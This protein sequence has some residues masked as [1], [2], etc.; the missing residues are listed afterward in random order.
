[1]FEGKGFFIW[2][3]EKCAPDAQTLVKRA[4][5]A[6]LKHVLIKIADGDKMFPI[7]D[8][9]GSKEK[10][11][12]ESIAALKDAGITVGGWSFIY[13]SKP[14]PRM[15]ARRFVQRLHHFGL[16]HA[17]I[18][19]EK[20]RNNPWT[21]ENAQKFMDEF[22]LGLGNAKI[23]DPILAL[24]SY[25]YIRY[26]SDFPFDVFMTYCQV[27]MP[28]VYWVAKNGGDPIRNLQD[29]FDEYHSRYP[30]KVFIP[31][32]AT[33]GER[34]ALGDETFYWEA[35]PDQV[36]LFF[37][38]V[39]AMDFLGTNFWSWQH[40]W[41]KQPLWEAV[42]SYPFK[43]EVEKISIVIN[44]R[45]SNKDDTG[46]PDTTNTAA[47][48]LPDTTDD[49]EAIIEVGAPG[50]QE[51]IYE[52]SGAEL[53]RFVRNGINCT[54]VKGEARRSTAYAQWV[55]RIGVSGDYL[56]EAWIP[57]INATAKRARYHITG[58]VGQDSTTLVELNQLNFSDEWVRL[59]IFEL[60]GGHQFSGMV[61]LSNLVGSEVN[62]RTQ[63]A[64][65]PIRWRKIERTGITPGFADGFDSPVGTA[66]ERALPN[67]AWGSD[68]KDWPGAWYD[69]NP[70]LRYYFLGWH[71]GIDLNLPGDKD[72]GAPCYAIGDGEITYSGPIYLRDGRL[73]GFGNL[74]IIKHDPYRTITGEVITVYSRYAHIKNI[75]VQTGE[76]VRRG[77]HIAT[78]WNVGTKAHHLHFDMSTT[79]IFATS[80]GHWPG[81]RKDLVEK[82]YVDPFVFIRANRPPGLG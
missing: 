38:Q 79:G 1:V 68:N 25:R 34:Q 50:Y 49:G 65:T 22:I 33:Y 59:G 76:K 21:V 3:I 35:Q 44:R 8:P 31:T 63:V 56:I 15:Q 67:S 53:T 61:S 45:E 23:S 55:P 75:V 14:D 74:V 12:T 16:N 27:A 51:G 36:K 10:L 47:I 40:A 41:A 69:A 54:W 28:Q 73:S 18:N 82:H 20:M 37:N 11:T 66:Q 30:S 70:Y 24:S 13:G 58:V 80:P 81:E 42:A 46:T 71:T 78:V 52:G 6:G 29:A 4:Q 62:P 77:D 60:D 32:G 5:D 7:N 26:H 39:E 57:G 2:Q 43:E 48:G 17:V 72:R 64:F 19:A 9:D